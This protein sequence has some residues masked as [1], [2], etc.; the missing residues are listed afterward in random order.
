VNPHEQRVLPWPPVTNT[1]CLL[2]FKDSVSPG[3]CLCV[4]APASLHHPALLASFDARIIYVPVRLNALTI[5]SH[6]LT[7]L[8][9]WPP[10]PRVLHTL[11]HGGRLR[12]CV[13]PAHATLLRPH[14]SRPWLISPACSCVS[15]EFDYPAW[16][17]YAL[18]VWGDCSL[19]FANT[20]GTR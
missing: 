16:L 15:V 1:S 18:T 17:D 9:L 13:R 3:Y 6:L 8:Q 7:V 19:C 14:Q 10:D 20:T 2:V 4:A 11:P 12:P 5:L